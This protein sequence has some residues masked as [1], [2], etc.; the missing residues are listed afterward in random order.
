[1]ASLFQRLVIRYGV[2]ILLVLMS[3]GMLYF[4]CSF[5]L[6]TRSSIRLFHDRHDDSWYGYVPKPESMPYRPGDTLAVE[7][8]PVGKMSFVAEDIVAEEGMLRMELRLVGECPPG[9]TYIEGFIYV[10][11]EK[12]KD[13]IMNRSLQ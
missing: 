1:M 2:F 3:M 6:R 12:I 13:K 10:G 11:K 4:I 5:E 8:T 7:Q 9:D